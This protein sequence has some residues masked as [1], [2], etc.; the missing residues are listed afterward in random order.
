MPYDPDFAPPAKP[1]PKR[2]APVSRRNFVDLCHELT[3]I[4]E[5]AFEDLWRRVGLSVN[6]DG[7][8]TTIGDETLRVSQLA[9]CATSSA[10]RRTCPRP[11]PV[12]RDLPDRGRPGRAGGQGL[13]G[14]YDQVAFHRPDGGQ[15]VI[16]TIRPELIA[17]C[18][19]LSP[20]PDD[21]RDADL[22]GQR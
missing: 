6:W 16:E 15:A 10:T 19:A 4:D 17:T 11:R 20:I 7:L 1:D 5:K 8:Y 22:V 12:G 3:H 9:F 18:V 13:S 14:A 2:Q 21:E